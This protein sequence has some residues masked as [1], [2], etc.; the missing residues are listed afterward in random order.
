MGKRYSV[1]GSVR[2]TAEFVALSFVIG[3]DIHYERWPERGAFLTTRTKPV[4]KKKG[5]R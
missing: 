3:G 1:K 2:K 4:T 5:R